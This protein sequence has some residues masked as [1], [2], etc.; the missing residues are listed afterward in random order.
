MGPP[1]PSPWP[2]PVWLMGEP[3]AARLPSPAAAMPRE[4]SATVRSGIDALGTALFERWND[5][6]ELR[7]RAHRLLW[8]HAEQLGGDPGCQRRVSSMAIFS[9]AADS[10]ALTTTS[11]YVKMEKQDTNPIQYR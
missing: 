7:Q 11:S 6:F 3:D 9:T 2:W 8:G 4:A 5:A 10:P 1:H